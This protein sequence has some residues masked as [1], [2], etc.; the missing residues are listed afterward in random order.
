MQIAT[1]RAIA[2]CAIVGDFVSPDARIAME[3]EHLQM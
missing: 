3:N 1:G 2:S